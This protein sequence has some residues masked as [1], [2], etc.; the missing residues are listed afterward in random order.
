[1]T[2]MKYL[3][4]LLALLITAIFI[5]YNGLG[6]DFFLTQNYS[7]GTYREVMVVGLIAWLIQPVL[8]DEF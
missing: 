8:F 5:D 4:L 3:K 6:G 1:M 2:A 7:I